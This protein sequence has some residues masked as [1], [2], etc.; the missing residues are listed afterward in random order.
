M[1]ERTAPFYSIYIQLRGQIIDHMERQSEP[2]LGLMPHPTGNWE[3]QVSAVQGF[4][5][6]EANTNYSSLL[7]VW[8]T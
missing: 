7:R 4:R 1:E 5:S 6:N 2:T 8:Q 3:W